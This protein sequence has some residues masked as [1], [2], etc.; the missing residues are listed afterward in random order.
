M[1]NWDSKHDKLWTTVPGCAR[2]VQDGDK[3][4]LEGPALASPRAHDPTARHCCHQE[5]EW[6]HTGH[7]WRLFCCHTPSQVQSSRSWEKRCQEGTRH[8]KDLLGIISVKNKRGS[9]RWQRETLDPEKHGRR[10]ED[11][12]GSVRIPQPGH[13]GSL[14]LKFPLKAARSHANELH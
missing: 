10:K 2:P 12:T 9:R 5:G 7:Y 4:I 14:K 3:M 6:Q 11:C 8:A 1:Q 13:W